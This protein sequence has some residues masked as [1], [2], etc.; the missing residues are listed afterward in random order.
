M[1]REYCGAA[2]QREVFDLKD[3]LQKTLTILLAVGI[4]IVFSAFLLMYVRPMKDVVLDLSLV[5]RGEVASSDNVDEMGWEVF[6]R[7]GDVITHLEP[8][9]GGHYLGIELGQTLYLSRV[10]NE[11]LDNPTL[12]L[13]AAE[14]TFSVWLDDQLIYTDRP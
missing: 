10:L 11:E 5:A 3:R 14:R 9:G 6:T 13:G 7:E 12:Q 4:A 1:Y 2:P 8:A